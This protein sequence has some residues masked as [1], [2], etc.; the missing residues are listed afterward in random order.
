M[1][2]SIHGSNEGLTLVGI[3]NLWQMFYYL[4]VNWQVNSFGKI[5]V[6]NKLPVGEMQVEI[7]R[8]QVSLQC[9]FLESGLCSFV[10]LG[11]H[12][13]TILIM[14]ADQFQK[15]FKNYWKKVYCVNTPDVEHF[16]K[17]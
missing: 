5:C 9:P 13:W 11:L 14:M 16:W 17:C 8:L 4:L 1:T 6:T 3:C 2:G 7:A 12:P 15:R 10:Q